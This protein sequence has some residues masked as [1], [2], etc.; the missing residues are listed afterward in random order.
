MSSH[1]PPDEEVSTDLDGR[2]REH[3]ARLEQEGAPDPAFGDELFGSLTAPRRG[4]RN[5]ILGALGLAAALAGVAV[6]GFTLAFLRPDPNPSIDPAASGTP[7][8]TEVA[9]ATSTPAPTPSPTETASPTATLTASP[10]ATAEPSPTASA[11]PAA[12]P[13]PTA[14][15]TPTPT[16]EPTDVPTDAPLPIVEGTW[17]PIAAIPGLPPQESGGGLADVTLGGDGL[18]Y[19]IAWGSDEYERFHVYD[20]GSDRWTE[21]ARP[22]AVGTGS[23]LLGGRDGLVYHVLGGA[24]ETWVWAF[25]PETAEW[26][27]RRTVAIDMVHDAVVGPD[28]RMLFVVD[29][30]VVNRTESRM[31]ALDLTSGEIEE[32]ASTAGR[33]GRY[34]EM[35]PDGRV[36]AG[37]ENGF[38]SYEPETDTW[39]AESEDGSLESFTDIAAG[40]D[41]RLYAVVHNE[42]GVHPIA[43]EPWTGQWVLVESGPEEPATPDL[44][45]GA[46][47]RLYAIETLGGGSGVGAA[48]RF[49]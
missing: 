21:L 6:L 43:W 12:T 34:I 10:T 25:D 49:D 24:D 36:Y 47:G 27:E 33:F 1:L 26:S 16:A 14:P 32:L 17:E 15:P 48:L 20:P 28:G 7:L 11:P 30:L 29:A 44:V 35:T 41:G 31:S 40:S 42:P 18:L 8:P 2:L 13:P 39:R 38:A 22:E 46:D 3:H 37:G 19:A 4:D 9:V 5:V 23:F 45:T